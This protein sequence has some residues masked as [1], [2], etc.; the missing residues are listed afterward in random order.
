VGSCGAIFRA[1]RTA[2]YGEA[3]HGKE[4]AGQTLQATALINEVYLRLVDFQRLELEHRAQFLALSAQVMRHVLVDAARARRAHKRGGGA[5]QVSLDETLGVS[6]G[7]DESFLALNNAL[8]TFSQVAPRQA[9]VVELRYFGGMSEEETAEAM[10]TSP[11]TVSRDWQFARA[12]LMRQ[13]RGGRPAAYPAAARSRREPSPAP[14]S[15][16][17]KG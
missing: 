12:W 17:R 6:P 15:I 3:V 1:W 11:R 14:A 4:R 9:K 16:R 10:K 2:P 7:N 5:I 13:L 8:E